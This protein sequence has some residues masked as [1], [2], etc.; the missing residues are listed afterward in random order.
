[1]NLSEFLDSNQTFRTL[2]TH[3]RRRVDTEVTAKHVADKDHLFT[4][5]TPSKGIY[6]IISGHFR[7]DM[8][9]VSGSKLML[10]IATPGNFIGEQELGEKSSYPVTATAMGD[11]RAYLLP[12]NLVKAFMQENPHFMESI[13]QAR[14]DSCR[15]L[16]ELFVG[17]TILKPEI[18][19]ARIL[20]SIHR[21]FNGGTNPEIG[22]PITQDDLS[23]MIASSRQNTSKIMKRWRNSKIVQ[24]GYAEIDILQL[25]E[26]CQIAQWNY[27][28]WLAGQP[29]S[30][31]SIFSRV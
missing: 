31:R 10:S 4:Q 27:E 13:L 25:D 29:K 30:D 9:H 23:D 28:T 1:M 21:I 16:V 19:L 22:Y 3:Q 12:K 15:S 11:S 7:L 14:D 18:R 8:N 24:T 20:L 5:G 6:L 17:A 2:S 26:L